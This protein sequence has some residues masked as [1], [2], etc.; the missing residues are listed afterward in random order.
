MAAMLKVSG[1]HMIRGGKQQVGF[2]HHFLLIASST[3][4]AGGQA[5]RNMDNTFRQVFFLKYLKGTSYSY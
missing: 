5:A 1:H 4:W 2:P 3:E